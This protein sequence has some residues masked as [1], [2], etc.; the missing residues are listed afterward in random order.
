MSFRRLRWHYLPI[1]GICFVL[2]VLAV[3]EN[4]HTNARYLAWRWLAVGDWQYGMRF[5]N[6]D[7]AFRRS[8]E[9]QPKTR[10]MRWFPDLRPGASRPDACP[11]LPEYADFLEQRNKGEWIGRTP[12]LVVYDQMGLVKQFWL[13]KGC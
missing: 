12:W 10:L 6:I 7:V 1:A 3:D 8:F 4:R 11:N 2:A 13:V 9:G 5:F